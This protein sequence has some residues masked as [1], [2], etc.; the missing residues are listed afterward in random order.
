VPPR[1]KENREGHGFTL[2]EKVGVALDFGWRS[3]LPLR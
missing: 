2:A 3:G 1:Q